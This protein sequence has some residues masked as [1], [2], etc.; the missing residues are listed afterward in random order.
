S[1]SFVGSPYEQQPLTEIVTKTAHQP[2][3]AVIFNHASQLW[4]E[5]FFLQSLASSTATPS[6]VPMPV[7][8]EQKLVDNFDS[9]E[10][11][12]TQFTNQALTMF[13][14]GWVW[15]VED[16]MARWRI[17]NT[18]NAGSPLTPQRMQVTDA[19]VMAA[20]SSASQQ[21]SPLQSSMQAASMQDVVRPLLCLN[22]W[23]HVYVPD[24]GIAGRDAYID[25]FWNNVD[26]HVVQQRS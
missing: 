11:F 23:E 21:Q 8:I 17:I 22:L 1:A 9:V 20:V 12:K 25:A 18:F 3:D 10:H 16:N 24:H 13:G 26:W 6:T 2:N 7:A 5:E 14:S 4:N 15:L 19:N